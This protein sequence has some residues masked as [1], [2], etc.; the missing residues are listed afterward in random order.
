M[1]ELNGILRRR[2]RRG[3]RVH[4]GRAREQSRARQYEARALRARHGR[5]RRSTAGA[6]D[7]PKRAP[8]RVLDATHARPAPGA[9]E[10]ADLHPDR[11]AILVVGD[12]DKVRDKLAE[13]PYGEP[14]SSTRKGTPSQGR[15]TRGPPAGDE[16]RRRATSQARAE[17]GRLTSGH[18]ASRGPRHGQAVREVERADRAEARRVAEPSLVASGDAAAG[19]N[20]A[21]DGDGRIGSG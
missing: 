6:D 8:D 10:E 2:R 13:L 3:A 14:S 7:Y 12:A 20:C 17:S 21:L 19:R 4:Q 16:R 9:R 15:T 11:M 5:H 18:I 1:K